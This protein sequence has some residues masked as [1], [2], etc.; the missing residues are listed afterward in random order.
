MPRKKTRDSTRSSSLHAHLMEELKKAPTH[1]VRKIVSEKLNESDVEVSD[2]ILERIVEHIIHGD[3]SELTWDDGRPE[4]LSVKLTFTDED[5]AK[6]DEAVQRFF[7]D[8][9]EMIHGIAHQSARLLLRS[10]KA[11]WSAQSLHERTSMEGFLTNLQEVWGEP[12]E[13]LKMLRTIVVEIGG[14]VHLR[15]ARSKSKHNRVL[16]EVLVKL[17]ARSCQILGEIITLLEHGY[18]D[19]GMAR[20]RTLYEIGVVA[21]VI[22]DGGDPLAKMYLEHEA[23]ESK[24]ALD[25]YNQCHEALGYRPVRKR[26]REAVNKAFAAA[27]ARYGPAFGKPHGWAA[28]HL[29][30]KKV[31]FI[32]LEGAAQRSFMRSYY[33]LASFNV[34]ADIKGIT[35]RLG[36]LDEQH[37]I[38]AGASNAGLEEPGQNA[39]ITCV[40]ITTLLMSDRQ[41]NVDTMVQMLV[42]ATL[43]DEIVDAFVSAHR[44]VV[45][46]HRAELKRRYQK[47]GA[48]KTDGPAASQ[49]AGQRGRRRAGK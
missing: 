26:S 7:N 43:R 25:R 31:D 44:R 19:G 14:E 34:H 35:H 29:G 39:A 47:S 11:D 48:R 37:G 4:E 38:L 45:R 15:A 30:K 24:L 12:L 18:A 28:Q 32:D 1:L 49:K 13:L 3:G 27:I 5:V 41:S 10:L 6:L 23:V 2:D 22:A 36:L 21:E 9:P 20:W 46:A 8:L 33:K 16:R 17:H 42:M 40:Q